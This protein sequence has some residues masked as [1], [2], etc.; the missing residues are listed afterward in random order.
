MIKFFKRKKIP[1]QLRSA[2][3][4]TFSILL[5]KGIV[6]LTIP[7]FT[8]IMTTSEMGTVSLYNSWFTLISSFS[9][10]ALTSGGFSLALKEFDNERNQYVSSVLSLTTII[11]LIISLIYFLDMSFWNKILGLPSYLVILMLLG[12]IFNPAQEFWLT[13]NKFE[14]KYRL[15]GFITIFSVLL[16]SI[17]SIVTVL[18]L[19]NNGSEYVA[20]G[21]ILSNFVTIY[22][23]SAIIWVYLI[24]KGKTFHSKKYWLYSLKISIPLV[25]YQVASQ[26]LSVSD[27]LMID[28][29]QGKSAVGI[30]STLY[31]VSAIS[32]L[33][34]NALNTC[35]IPYLFQNIDK[36]KN[37]IKE[38]SYFLLL[39]YAIFEIVVTLLSPEIVAIIGTNEYFEAIYIMPPVASGVFMISI[40]NMY[41]NILVYY[42]K[43]RYIMI[44]S[45]IAA[46]INVILNYIL[47]PPFGY[48]AAAYTTL[49]SYLL[50]AF[51]IMHYSSNI[52]KENKIFG[53]YDDKKLFTL[54]IITILVSISGILI[55]GY[56][57]IRY[58]VV[59]FIVFL[60]IVYVFNNVDSI[61]KLK[62]KVE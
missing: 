33:L 49:F 7:I 20:E 25:G 39:S 57:I 3:V 58:I 38:I 14:Y 29:F 55:Y 53:I 24:L 34:W 62:K 32:L 54:S 2:I 37:K 15:S 27:R 40:S 11:A 21:R 8:R 13:R 36:K 61:K 42:K 45:F 19:S 9:T 41:S 26:I 17:L 50:M 18:I 48:I 59:L 12:L 31:S 6:F 16:S 44:A 10:L 56:N 5:S 51:I 23:F 22:C 46:I 28:W 30:Y 60:G 52:M 35:F 43:T 1:I 4:Y 47:I